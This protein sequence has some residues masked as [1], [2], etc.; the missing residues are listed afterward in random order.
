MG[1]AATYVT[2]NLRFPSNGG[3]ARS[4]DASNRPPSPDPDH[5]PSF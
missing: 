3:D 2:H 1:D 5:K 4:S